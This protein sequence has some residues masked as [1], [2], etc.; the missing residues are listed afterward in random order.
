MCRYGIELQTQSSDKIY[1]KYTT[2]LVIRYIIM[3]RELF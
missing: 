2:R 1:V 3:F